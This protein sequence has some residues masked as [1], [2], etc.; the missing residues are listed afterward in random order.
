M[1]A[2]DDQTEYRQTPYA[3]PA[4]ATEVLLVRHG[5]S[6][7]ARPDSPFPL[8]DGH[9]D[10]ELASE[11]RV[12]A[13]RVGERLSAVPLD[14]VYVTSLRRT[15]E[16]AAPLVRRNGLEP[17]VEKDLREVHL[18]EWEGGLFR[19]M[20]H[21]NGPV[22]RR[23]WAEERWDVIPGGEPTEVFA[24]RV[25]GAIDRIV[26]AHPDARVAVFTHGG[27][28][29]QALALASG[30]RPFAFLGADNGSIS[31]LVVVG[32]QWAVRRFNDTAH[33]ETDLE[34]GFTP[35]T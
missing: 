35:L 19:K 15:A 27:V 6:Q 13:E 8:V 24:A 21:E 32:G 29:A 4:G 25:R 31:Q 2:A 33:L 22:A 17:L 11:G 26:A 5:A 9:G 34:A 1:A 14:A 7:A 28:I 10:P 20:I 23:L 16:T 12:Q 18:G 3:P 30:S